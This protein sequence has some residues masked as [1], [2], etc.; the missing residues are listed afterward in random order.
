MD[1]ECQIRENA[2]VLGGLGYDATAF[3]Y[4]CQQVVGIKEANGG[5]CLPPKAA[6]VPV[7]VPDVKGA[8]APL[9]YLPPKPYKG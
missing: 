6:V 1:K 4:M 9:E 5:D 2:R 3:V 8:V 7:V